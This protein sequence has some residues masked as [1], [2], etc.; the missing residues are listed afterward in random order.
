MIPDED[1]LVLDACTSFSRSI[2]GGV[3]NTRCVQRFFALRRNGPPSGDPPTR[4]RD[5]A[6]LPVSSPNAG[7][8]RRRREAS[9]ARQI[10]RI[11][12]RCRLHFLSASAVSGFHTGFGRR[13]AGFAEIIFVH[14]APEQPRQ[15]RRGARDDRRAARR[16]PG[17]DPGSRGA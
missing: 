11:C 17:G 16:S 5:P 8:F 12:R 7:S 9:V 1:A 15:Q 14:R 2:A 6:M 4:V 13:V 3:R 10:R